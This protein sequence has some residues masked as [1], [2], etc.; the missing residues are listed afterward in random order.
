MARNVGVV[1]GLAVHVLATFRV[2]YE[3]LA[4]HSVA[5]LAQYGAYLNVAIEE[6]GVGYSLGVGRKALAEVVGKLAG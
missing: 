6:L 1:L 3:N 2:Y 5:V 4:G